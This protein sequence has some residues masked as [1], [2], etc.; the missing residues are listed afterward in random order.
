[1]NK[2]IG[3]AAQLCMA[4]RM[5]RMQLQSVREFVKEDSSLFLI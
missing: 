5:Q 2:K 4:Q 3:N 1:M